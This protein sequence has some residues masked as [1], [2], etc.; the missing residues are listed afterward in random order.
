M[1]AGIIQAVKLKYRKRQLQHVLVEIE[2]QP[3]KLGPEILRDISV[4]QAI[5]WVNSVWQE[6]KPDTIPR[7]FAKC[8]FTESSVSGYVDTEVTF[9]D[10]DSED[11]YPLSVLKM[12]TELFGCQFQ[13][14][15]IDRAF[16]TCDNNLMECDRPASEIL[17]DLNL[18]DTDACDSDKEED[19]QSRSE[20]ISA[21]DFAQYLEKMK[22]HA[23]CKNKPTLLNKLMDLADVFV[24][25]RTEAT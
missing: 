5:Y 22:R 9:E 4:L 20:G 8:G 14:L 6:V 1:D 25:Y 13:E 3:S 23:L 16:H 2:K 18:T 21:S 17:R 24:Q 7:C 11:D 15:D 19:I 10:E 12:S